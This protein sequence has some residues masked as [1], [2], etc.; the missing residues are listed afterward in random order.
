[1]LKI[2]ETKANEITQK[3]KEA[4]KKKAVN[5]VKKVANAMNR[6]AIRLALK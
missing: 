4:A 2:K 1:M 3:K 6:A 5:E